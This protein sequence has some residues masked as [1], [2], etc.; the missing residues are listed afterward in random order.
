MKTNDIKEGF[1]NF[2]SKIN[3]MMS[4]REQIEK[5]DFD[6]DLLSSK[7]DRTKN[8]LHEK[9]DERNRYE[10]KLNSNNNLQDHAKKSIQR[11]LLDCENIIKT[12][13]ETLTEATYS[14]D[15]LKEEKKQLQK[16]LSELSCVITDNDVL[17]FQKKVAAAKKII[18]NITEIIERKNELINNEK[19]VISCIKEFTIKK[20]D[21]LADI[22]LG[23]NL[24]NDLEKITQKIAEEEKLLDKRE[25]TIL[26]IKKSMP[27]LDRKLS[28]A[29][30]NLKNL[31]SI[32]NEIL[33]NYLMREAEEA[34][35]EYGDVASIL[36]DKYLRLA[37]LDSLIIQQGGKTISGSDF[38][39]FAIPAFHLNVL[40][41]LISPQMLQELVTARKATTKENRETAITQ[42]IKRINDLGIEL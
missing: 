15:K 8:N 42:E 14:I 41:P 12:L 32:R 17:E 10:Q 33:I 21:I 6:V 31:E 36:I 18:K 25:K 19:S 2:E 40:H 1:N 35:K 3:S 34:G 38:H 16:Y 22:A 9:R 23:K 26:E 20:E 13:Q 28:I 29:I 37:S 11:D 4:I 30:N 27:G 5:N 39:D 24:Q 7:I